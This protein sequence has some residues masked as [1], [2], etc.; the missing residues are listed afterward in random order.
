MKL[1]CN[2]CGLCCSLFYINL[3]KIEYESLEYETMFA[4]YDCPESFTESKSCG[5]NLLAKKENGEC[6]YLLEN[7][8]SIHKKR[9]MACRNFFCT[10][11]AKKFETMVK[12][13]KEN[14]VEKTSSLYW[15]NHI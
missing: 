7:Q 13:I 2:G 5:A 12:V 3:T 10:T 11:K 1:S 15:Q 8:C 4:E 9:P 14:D 6:I